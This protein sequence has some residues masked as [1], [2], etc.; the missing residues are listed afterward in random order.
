MDPEVGRRALQL[1]EVPE[2]LAHAHHLH[3]YG[4]ISF[5]VEVR[6]PPECL[7]GNL[8]LVRILMPVVPKVLQQSPERGRLLKAFALQYLSDRPIVGEFR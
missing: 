3:A 2:F 1:I 7:D 8:R 4:G 6:P 5:G